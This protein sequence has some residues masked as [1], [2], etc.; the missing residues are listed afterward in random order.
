M[1]ARRGIRVMVAAVALALV[2]PA[3]SAQPGGAARRPVRRGDVTGIE[4]GLEGAL[5][6]S[7][8]QPL[9]WLLALHEVVG[10]QD[11]RPAPNAR[12]TILSSLDPSG[13]A[14]TATADAMG[15]AVVEIP[16]PDDAP[17]SFRVVI[18]AAAANGV[19]R[20]FE[21]DVR[22][23]DP[24]ILT[25]HVARANIPRGGTLRVFGRLEHRTTG[26]G[27]G[28]RMVEL[29][30][31]DA[32][33][34]PLRPPV[35][36]RTEAAGLFARQWRL[37]R[38]FS[39]GVVVKARAME[40]SIE[41]D[42]RAVAVEAGATVADPNAPAMLVAVRADRPVIAP[43][44]TVNLEIVVRTRA[45]RPVA[46][47]VVQLP[48]DPTVPQRGGRPQRRTDARGRVSGTFTARGAFDPF[49]DV[50]IQVVASKAG[51]GRATGVATVRVAAV[52][53][54][55][56]L[57]VEGG[58]VS[59]SLG[60]RV[61]AR[62][63]TIDGRS[64]PA[65]IP[66]RF[67]GPRL[68]PGGVEVQT[69]ADGVAM[70]EAEIVAARPDETDACGGIAATS[71]H[72]VAGSGARAAELD[73]CIPLDPDAAALVRTI[74]S[75]VASGGHV[76]VEVARAREA[77]GRPVA[78][79]LLADEPT[80]MRAVASHVLGANE[81]VTEIAIPRDVVGH[82]LVRARPLIGNALQEARGGMA[83][84]WVTPGE[85]TAVEVG[86]DPAT[87]AAPISF[88]GPARGDRSL[89]AVA[90]PIDE[91]RDLHR[92]I[93][94]M[95]SSMLADLRRPAGV[96]GER[97]IA[98]ALATRT[99]L[100]TG[101]PAVL[102]GGELVPVPAPEAPERIGL[103]R[104]PW[105]A[106]ARFV[107]GRLQLLFRA[108]EA[109]IERSIPQQIDHVAEQTATGWKFNEQILASVAASGTL[110]DAGATGLGGETLTID[111]LRGLDPAFS[112]DNVARRLTRERLFILLIALRDFVREQ[113]LD[114]TWTRRGEPPT[115]L[116][117]MRHRWAST[118]RTIEPRMLVD[119]WGRPFQLVP[120]RG[121]RARFGRIEAVA[122]YE[123]VS[124]GP[125]GR[126][127]SGDDLWD[128]TARVLPANSL[129]AR[130]VGEDALVARLR[131][132][133]LGRATI[134]AASGVFG[135]GVGYVPPPESAHHAA[136]RDLWQLPPIHEPDPWALE[137]RRPFEPGDGAG[138]AIHSVGADGG[139][140]AL[141]LDEEPRTWGVVVAAFTPE[142]WASVAL[143]GARGGAPVLIE[144]R[145]PGRIRTS[146]PLELDLHVTNVTDAPVEYAL[147][148]QGEGV[149]VGLPGSI[150][151]PPGEARPIAARVEASEGGEASV[152]IRLRSGDSVARRITHTFAVDGGLH[153]IRRRA[154]GFVRNGE[155]S[156]DLEIPSNAGEPTGRV[157]LLTGPALGD[158]PYL[159]DVRERDP[160]LIAWANTVSGRGVRSDLRAALLRA[161][162]PHGLLTGD[163]P[164][165]STA[166]ALVA[167]SSA[168]DDDEDATAARERALSVLGSIGPLDDRGSGGMIRAQSS[169]LAALAVAGV[170]E[171]ADAE[172]H[173]LDPVSATTASLR[174]QLRGALHT[175][176]A[177]P[178]LLARAAAALL[179]ADPRDG[180]GLAMLD[181]AARSLRRSGRGALVRPSAERDNDGEVL[182]ATLAL[183][184]AAHQA[185]RVELAAELLRGALTFDHVVTRLGGET[186]FW[187]LAAG[188]YGSLGVGAPD[189]L[190]LTIEG[191]RANVALE[192][193]RAVVALSGLARG[194]S[195][196]IEV[197]ARGETAVLA[198]VEA[199]FGRP[200]ARA[201]DG[202][203]RME[204]QGEP[205]RLGELA[206]LELTV[207]SREAIDG[208]VVDLQLPAGVD[209]DDILLD[210]LR[211]H[212]AISRVES[213][214]PGYIQLR[215]RPLAAETR[216]AIPLP[217]EWRARGTLHGLAA[218][219]YPA[220][221]PDA[222]TILPPRTLEIR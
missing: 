163:A 192:H 164:A 174:A 10:L 196:T 69:D 221:R 3:V 39:G 58:A 187:Y 92:R 132:V 207:S 121:G 67:S 54:G 147:E 43:N 142:G 135:A 51:L 143:A 84:L 29:R 171:L 65:G 88:Q 205:G 83:S 86:L 80:G 139:S 129:Y 208:A 146:E 50:P 113:Q 93:D 178:S 21:L 61:Y 53:H 56:A 19:R 177:E 59:P 38:D 79:A 219:A 140:V 162:M 160:A 182:T 66:V 91:A 24:R 157:V 158:D 166:C 216:I 206:A 32:Q 215:L 128:P 155:W 75:V 115:W 161:Q 33:G 220:S 156:V 117:M 193:G 96:A 145:L 133:E 101:A 165:L 12:V 183:A 185:G 6:V 72:V 201:S 103:L 180:H 108:I 104:D 153:P 172:E 109:Q 22:T 1:S 204:I 28:D 190:T 148:A 46:D 25:L 126:F 209:A 136:G 195:R 68:A 11:L 105:R 2:A 112:Y 63:V 181:R 176:P 57:S 82:V 218:I 13:P 17:D 202:P 31:E 200:F 217:L 5:A 55:V 179:V 151:I 48:G 95:A 87:R 198:R 100:D 76:R 41:G 42:G 107:G 77:A 119:G 120:A 210:S 134:E 97:L 62:V 35:R 26:R 102:R 23:L 73:R 111:M 211:A 74:P 8:G 167:W 81:T 44:E 99:P 20:R 144:Q 89:I 131:G 222:M 116:E 45:G 123:L 90:L 94:A 114:L 188:A 18:E 78:I 49:G 30:L 16:V 138:G 152:E 130:A 98:A 106:R 214:E 184:V 125:D 199:V 154:A 85:R 122:G 37:P 194:G 168:G 7:R 170:A 110:G 141:A 212:A 52:D 191:R 27:L 197:T 189:R 36:E 159:A 34:R 169:V 124:S 127:G 173:E 213:R 71:F 60:G 149:T 14:A 70:L 47:A 40:D 186:A 175:H 64:A 203:L 4:L 9:R 15:R 118:G 150:A 137:V